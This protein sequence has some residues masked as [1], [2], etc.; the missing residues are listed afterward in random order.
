MGDNRGLG[1]AVPHLGDECFYI[2]E[3]KST[4]H[5]HRYVILHSNEDI[6]HTQHP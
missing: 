1:S 6:H 3:L 4:I 5:R 2:H